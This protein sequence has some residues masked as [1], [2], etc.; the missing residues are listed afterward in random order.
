MDSW[1][2]AP[3]FQLRERLTKLELICTT[4]TNGNITGRENTYRT[5]E[6]LTYIG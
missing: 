3:T 5:R 4:T 2:V 1:A 6:L